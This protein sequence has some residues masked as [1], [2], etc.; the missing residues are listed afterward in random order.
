MCLIYCTPLVLELFNWKVIKQ[1]HINHWSRNDSVI[2]TTDSQPL[3]LP[4]TA[5]PLHVCGALTA[6]WVLSGGL[7]TC[8]NGI[9]IKHRN[10]PQ[11][12]T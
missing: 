5:R 8:A 2:N 12:A 10:L 6:P 11:F 3:N 1:H 9:P 4:H 7:G